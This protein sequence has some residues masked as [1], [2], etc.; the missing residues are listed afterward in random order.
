MKKLLRTAG[1]FL[2]LLI[3]AHITLNIIWGMQ[4]RN[5]IRDLKAQGKL[6]TWDEIKPPPVPD[7]ENAALLYKKVFELMTTG[8]GGEKYVAEDHLYKLNG[9]VD[10]IDRLRFKDFTNWTPEERQSISKLIQSP[11]MQKIYR[12]I[13]QAS[14]KPECNFIDYK[15]PEDNLSHSLMR[16]KLARLIFVKAQIEA[17][18]GNID[19][20]LDTLSTALRVI[21]HFKHDPSFTSQITYLRDKE[22]VAGLTQSFLKTKNVSPQKLQYLLK[23]YSDDIDVAASYIKGLDAWK[24]QNLWNVKKFP[25][26]WSDYGLNDYFNVPT[27]NPWFQR[28]VRVLP[29]F[30]LRYVTKLFFTKDMQTNLLAQTKEQEKWAMPLEQ[31]HKEIQNGMYG[32]DFPK[33]CY[34]SKYPRGDGDDIRMND[35]KIP[36]QAKL[37]AGQVGIALKVYRGEHENYPDSLDKLTPGILEKIP[38]DPFTGKG[39]VYKKTGNGFVLYSLGPDLQDNH[40]APLVFPPNYKTGE[41]LPPY[42]I[43]WKS[44]R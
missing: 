22:T 32:K 25:E 17:N 29:S 23:L 26:G 14:Q 9:T 31:L 28:L 35:W 1:I 34:F 30:Y 39:L 7:S 8:E 33:C 12:L 36:L 24:L 16:G 2:F 6:K 4:L 43:V 19:K 27:E 18:N 37:Y 44:E 38:D 3:A 41:K 10:T 15:N 42:D 21:N 5:T 13:Q 11:L 40:G 20:S